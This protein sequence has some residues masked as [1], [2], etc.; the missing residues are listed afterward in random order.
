MCKYIIL[1][2]AGICS[3][4]VIPI[5]TT[6]MIQIYH[7]SGTD[8]LGIDVYNSPG[9]L[10]EPQNYLTATLFGERASLVVY[11]TSLVYY[12]TGGRYGQGYITGYD[13]E[14]ETPYTITLGTY[15]AWKYPEKYP[16]QNYSGL[17]LVNVP[18]PMSFGLF[19]L[20]GFFMRKSR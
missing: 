3:A 17:Q 15:N 11:G 5:P 12:P 9:T 1:L 16:A 7:Y 18:E 19:S 2:I 8:L 14:L 10:E 20:V 13:V 6:D 4:A